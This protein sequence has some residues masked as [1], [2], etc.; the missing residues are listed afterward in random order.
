M[1]AVM[2][3]LETLGTEPGSVIVAIGAVRF[4][5]LAVGKQFYIRV[6][7][8]SCMEAGLKLDVSTVLWWL[9]QSDEARLELCKEGVPLAAALQQ[10]TGFLEADEDVE[11]WGNG[12]AF[13]NT[14]LAA[15]YKAMHLTPPW[16]F[17]NDRCYRT[18]RALNPEIKATRTGT[19]HNALDDAR[20]QAEHLIAILNATGR[21]QS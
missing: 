2:L 15:A 4:N 12:A 6:D 21:V 8:Q 20:T 7:A 16:A 18:I 11:M 9:K 5:R 14:L 1:N 19:H 3:D 10:F 17:W 13:D